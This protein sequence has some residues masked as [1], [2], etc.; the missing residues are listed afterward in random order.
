MVH[1]LI[2]IAVSMPLFQ[3][4]KI[5]EQLPPQ[6]QFPPLPNVEAGRQDAQT[7]VRL[8]RPPFLSS[9]AGRG[10]RTIKSVASGRLLLLALLFGNSVF[11]VRPKADHDSRISRLSL[12]YIQVSP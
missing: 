1:L 11:Q 2:P 6:A 10:L 12:S 8:H 5:I 9:M 4:L 7:A 3:R